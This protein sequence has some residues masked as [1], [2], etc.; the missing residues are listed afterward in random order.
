M[1]GLAGGAALLAMGALPSFVGIA[2]GGLVGLV[3]LGGLLSKDEDDKKA[4]GVL[5]AGGALA[6]VSKFSLPGL[7]GAAGMI[8]SLGG[9]GLL[10][11]GIWKG[12]KFFQGLKSRG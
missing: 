4:G 11:L 5:A 6:L 1:A 12:L 9:L 10:A 7:S 3:G 2:A 8:L